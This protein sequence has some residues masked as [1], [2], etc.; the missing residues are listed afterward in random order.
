MKKAKLQRDYQDCGV[1]CLA[2]LIEYYHGYVPIETLRDDTNTSRNGTTAYDLV[3]ALKKYHFDA[4]GMKI[5]NEQIKS[6]KCPFIAHVVLE[7]GL[8]HFVVVLSC[9]LKKIEIMDPSKGI[10]KY[11]YEDFFKIFDGVVLIAI[12]YQSIV[13]LPKEVGI[14][15]LFLRSLKKN[16]SLFLMLLLFELFFFGLQILSQFYAK[17]VLENVL[18]NAFLFFFFSFLGLFCFRLLFSYGMEKI[19]LVLEKNLELDFMSRFLKHILHLP[20]KK[21]YSYHE[22]EILKRVEETYELKDLLSSIGVTFFLESLFSLCSLGLLFF[23]HPFLAIFSFL[24]IIICILGHLFLSPF[25][26]RKINLQI[27]IETRWKENVVDFISLVPSSRHCNSLCFTQNKIERALNDTTKKRYQNHTRLLGIEFL[28]SF[29][30]QA[31]LFLLTSYGLYLVYQKE[32]TIIDFLTVQNLYLFLLKPFESLGQILPR[33]YYYKGIYQKVSEYLSI[34]EEDIKKQSSCHFS[35]IIVKHLSFSYPHQEDIIKD[36]SFQVLQGEHI[37]LKGKSGSGKSSLCKIFMKEL[38]L[39]RGDIYFDSFHIA[40]LK[41][42]DILANMVYLSQNERLIFGTI[43]ENILFGSSFEEERFGRVCSICRV[44]EIVSSKEMRYETTIREESLSGGEKQ[45][46]L[47]ARILY[48][49]VSVY[50]FDEPLEGV[51]EKL[52]ENIIKDLRVFLKEKTL[53]YISHRSLPSSFENV[54]NIC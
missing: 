10:C 35:S 37:F 54:V 45:R 2:Y 1:T 4:Y 21:Y 12:P 8:Y 16:K 38:D 24:G 6:I 15:S 31:M 19:K 26:S 51:E 29:Y 18:L 13:S 48:K 50:I 22:G 3:W 11:S 44:N 28:K 20:L 34:K 27:E 42:S 5:E 43:K 53:I 40:D 14:F 49:K 33:I 46:I 36:L 32:L 17:M 47:L 39:S 52:E 41:I 7:N 9:H 25:I 23:F 30:L